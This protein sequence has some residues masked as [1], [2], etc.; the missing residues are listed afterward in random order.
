[1]QKHCLISALIAFPFEEFIIK[2]FFKRIF[3][4][5]GIDAA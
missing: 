2:D 4:A 3:F 5:F 1:M